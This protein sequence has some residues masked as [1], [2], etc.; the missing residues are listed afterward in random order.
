MIELGFGTLKGWAIVAAS[1]SWAW[2]WITAL[3][4]VQGIQLDEDLTTPRTDFEWVFRTIFSRQR[5]ACYSLMFMV[6]MWFEG[7][8]PE[9]GWVNGTWNSLKVT[10]ALEQISYGISPYGNFQDVKGQRSK[11]HGL[12]QVQQEEGQKCMICYY[13]FQPESVYDPGG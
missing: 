12:Y 5:A 2:T 4:A 6:L 13:P 11:Q 9:G 8:A 7:Q 10:E 1:G 3:Q